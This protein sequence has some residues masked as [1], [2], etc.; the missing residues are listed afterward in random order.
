MTLSCEESQ[1][2][3]TEANARSQRTLVVRGS[4]GS[5]E[6]R[7]PTGFMS[8]L[9]RGAIPE[10]IPNLTPIVLH[11]VD[12]MRVDTNVGSLLGFEEHKVADDLPV[13][14]TVDT[15]N[16]I[17]I[18]QDSFDEFRERLQEMEVAHVA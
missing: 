6:A 2:G 8:L 11:L 4:G 10:A 15:V 16:F 12:G 13:F 9:R 3:K 18:V 14:C 1:T 17:F 5:V 7:T